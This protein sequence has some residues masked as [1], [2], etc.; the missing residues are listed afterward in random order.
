MN[1]I[2]AVNRSRVKIKTM[3]VIIAPAIEPT[4]TIR[5]SFTLSPPQRKT[6]FHECRV[7]Q[8]LDFLR[9]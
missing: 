6:H 7:S 3:A 2:G 9:Y 8:S 5:T 1:Q 4:N